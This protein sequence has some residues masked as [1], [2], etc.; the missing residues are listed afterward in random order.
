VPMMVKTGTLTVP[1]SVLDFYRAL[2]ERHNVDAEVLMVEA[3]RRIAERGPAPQES[4]P[5]P[6]P[7]P[8][9]PPMPAAARL[10][11]LDDDGL[12]P[13]ERWDAG[14]EPSLNLRLREK[15]AAPADPRPTKIVAVPMERPGSRRGMSP[16]EVARMFELYDRGMTDSDIARAVGRSQPPISKRLR[17][18]G[19]PPHGKR[20]AGGLPR[21]ENHPPTTP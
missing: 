6:R 1:A 3:L 21:K 18:S 17:D 7:A 2:A 19:R 16:D 10:P 8:V 11:R 20:G 15:P 13:L 9:G 5:A 14:E 4:A 12:P